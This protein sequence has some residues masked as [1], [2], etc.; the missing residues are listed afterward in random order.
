VREFEERREDVG[1]R[2][3]LLGEMAVRVEFRGDDDLRAD[4]RADPLQ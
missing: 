4:D 1:V 2:H 3:P